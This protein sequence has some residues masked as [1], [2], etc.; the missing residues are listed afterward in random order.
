MIT[1]K[2]SKLTHQITDSSIHVDNNTHIIKLPFETPK[3]IGLLQFHISYIVRLVGTRA[4]MKSYTD[5]LQGLV[6][7]RLKKYN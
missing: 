4:D 3:Y 7:S 1:K 6:S 5:M 2:K